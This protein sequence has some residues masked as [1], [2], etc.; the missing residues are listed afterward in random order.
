[1][2]T[3]I[4]GP[5]GSKR[6]RRFLFVPILLVA[7][8]AMFYIAG[9]QGVH[10]LGVFQLDGDAV[11]N[12]TAFP[13]ANDDWDKVCHQVTG[14]DCST[15]SNTTG[16]TAVAWSN[17]C[18][19]AQP[20]PATCTATDPTATS[21]RAASTFTGGGSKD[22]QNINAWAWNDGSGG[23][24]DKD[25]LVHAFAAR[26]N[27]SG[28]TSGVGDCAAN[29]TCD[30]LYF[31]LD[32][33]DNS[34]DA[35]TGIWFLQN[36][37]AEGTNKVGG[38]TGFA[39]TD[40][41]PGTDPSDDYHRN[42]DVLVLSDFSIGGTTSTISVLRWNSTCT[43]SGQVL[44][45]G[46]TCGDAN[47]E[48]L[49]TSTAAKCTPTLTADDFCGLVN[50]STITMPWSFTDKSGTA[51]NGA[52]NGE[53]YEAGIN[54]TPFGLGGE[55]FASI[56]SESR[57]STSTT[58]TLKDFVI[59]PFAPCKA[60]I[61]TS[62]DSSTGSTTVNPAQKVRDKATIT[63][64]KSGVFPSGNVEFFLCK[65][66]ST[67]TATTCPAGSG[68]DI[69]SGTLAAVANSDPPKSEAFSPYVNCDPANTTGCATGG[70]FTKNPLPTGHYCFR[71]EWPGDGNYIGKLV[72][73]GSISLECFDVVTIPTTTATVQDWIPNDSATISTT[74]PTG[75]NLTGD[76]K[77]DLYGPNDT[78]CA[79]T[80]VYEE[81]IPIPANSGLSATVR[82]TNGDGVGTGL[83]ADFIVKK[84]GNG[85]Y[86]WKVV[87]TP[88]STDTAH[89]GSSSACNTEHSLLTI[90]E[91]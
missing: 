60:T 12:T 70:T 56:V 7:C 55:C 5:T 1:M 40:P 32:R 21:D 67:S 44:G 27:V 37:C 49:K 42:G 61:A 72:E 66:D 14:T 58:A 48:L 69:G 26:Y 82:T 13:P 71:A 20:T 15:S 43:K 47:L 46:N 25:N 65:Y 52:L 36:A 90:T 28:G 53:F 11:T 85:T 41:T 38:G 62:V 35:Q 54:L 80:P 91:P 77:F 19:N 33:F 59:A 74:G 63:G 31:G 10:D 2:A 89:T 6:R 79:G 81:D 83:A 30:V 17:D 45:N 8:T 22:P 88:A 57:S 39:C 4:L 3:R 64:N 29:T 50:S 9:A 87:Y 75:Y 34:G 73:D 23:L 68:D 51:S 16:A 78:S 86:S 84:A 18:N 76:V 24:P